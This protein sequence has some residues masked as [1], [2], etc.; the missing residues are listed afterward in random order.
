LGKTLFKLFLKT[1][2]R[3]WSREQEIEG[4]QIVLQEKTECQQDL[5]AL[6][7]ELDDISSDLSQYLLFL[8]ERQNLMRQVLLE[9][10]G[11]NN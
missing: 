9:D 3:L 8:I 5:Q 10:P 4:N 2:D 6:I 1:V 7:H 11:C